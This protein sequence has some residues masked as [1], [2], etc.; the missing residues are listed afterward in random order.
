MNPQ[1]GLSAR[2]RR[3]SGVLEAVPIAVGATLVVARSGG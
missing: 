1:T 3:T 2:R